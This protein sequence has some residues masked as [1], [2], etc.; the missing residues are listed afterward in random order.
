M[1]FQQFCGRNDWKNSV[2]LYFFSLSLSLLEEEEEEEEDRT[3][4]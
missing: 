1:K 3:R 4:R 2:L